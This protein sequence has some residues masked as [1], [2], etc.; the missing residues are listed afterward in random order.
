MIKEL[1]QRVQIAF[2]LLIFGVAVVLGA[3]ASFYNQNQL[4]EKIKENIVVQNILLNS[5]LDI[6]KSNSADSVTSSLVKD[7]AKRTEYESLLIK[8]DR[9][10]KNELLNLQIL[11]ESCGDFYPDTKA[12]M[13]SRLE[14][15]FQ[16]YTKFIDLLKELD[17]DT[18]SDYKIAEWSEIIEVEKKRSELLKEQASVQLEIIQLLIQ[19]NSVQSK[20]VQEQIGS[21]QRIGVLLTTQYGRLEELRALL[22]Q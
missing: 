3:A 14:R 10:T 15:E 9:L 2:V 6:T 11:S 13:V 8:L 18:V 19:G 21:A 5:L 20:L 12:V 17:T 7:C 22:T 4:E 16:A 1:P